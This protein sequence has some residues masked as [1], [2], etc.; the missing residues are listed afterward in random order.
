MCSK[1]ARSA[2]G[3]LTHAKSISFESLTKEVGA[4]GAGAEAPTLRTAQQVVFRRVGIDH[5]AE[6]EPSASH[7]SHRTN[8]MAHLFGRLPPFV[9]VRL[10]LGPSAPVLPARNRI[11]HLSATFFND[12]VAI[13]AR[14][15]TIHQRAD[16][17]PPSDPLVHMADR[18]PIRRWFARHFGPAPCT[19]CGG[20]LRP[21]VCADLAPEAVRQYRLD[22]TLGWLLAAGRGR[23]CPVCTQPGNWVYVA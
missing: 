21:L 4:E 20:A 15:S 6:P 16:R 2:G 13:V 3:R 1:R 17:T 23:V 11:A 9:P 19:S 18:H 8:R 10:C 12:C 5:T 22:G 7:N 14:V